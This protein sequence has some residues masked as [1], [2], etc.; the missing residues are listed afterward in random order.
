MIIDKYQRSLFTDTNTVNSVEELDYIT[1]NFSEFVFNRPINT[2]QVT[3][4]DIQRPDLIAH[5]VY[6]KSNLW[7]IIMKY[8]KIE[9]IWNDLSIGQILNIPSILDIDEL[10]IKKRK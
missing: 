8:N 4:S 10:A 3:P 1:S 6:G 7:W 5:K 2:Y 9:D